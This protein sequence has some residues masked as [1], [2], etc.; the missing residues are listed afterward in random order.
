MSAQMPSLPVLHVDKCDKHLKSSFR[1]K[2]CRDK[3]TYTTGIGT[4]W[5]L[6][7]P[8]L[9]HEVGMDHA[10]LLSQE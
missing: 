8:F 9:A 2:S 10:Y 5:G 4:F 7:P 3:M 1:R 6:L